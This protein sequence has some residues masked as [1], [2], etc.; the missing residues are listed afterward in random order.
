MA[1]KNIVYLSRTKLDMYYPQVPLSFL[2]G[3]T[4]TVKVN[5]GVFASEIAAKTLD[6]STDFGRLIAILRYLDREGLVG[7]ETDARQFVRGN[8]RASALIDDSKAF[9]TGPLGKDDELVYVCLCASTKHI[10]GYDAASGQEPNP[11]FQATA[12]IGSVEAR[13]F[14]YNSNTIQFGETLTNLAALT[15][16]T[17]DAGHSLKKNFTAIDLL[18]GNLQHAYNR[19]RFLNPILEKLYP[20]TPGEL[21]LQYWKR[22]LLATLFLGPLFF[23]LLGPGGRDR[24]RRAIAKLRHK[25]SYED[26][27]TSLSEEEQNILN[28][29]YSV[30]T[31]RSTGSS[32]NYEFVARRMA[33]GLTSGGRNVLLASPLYMAAID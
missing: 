19:C 15:T 23:L 1:L 28:A 26:P 8:I 14:H 32:Q 9:F 11:A 5:L 10:A 33:Q 21:D 24:K 7:A 30:A 20:P 4:A 2:A 22:E 12:R 3:G 17:A 25:K 29:A 18:P 6:P 31:S 27:A 13:L 16:A